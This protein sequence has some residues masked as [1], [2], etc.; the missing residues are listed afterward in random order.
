MTY[1]VELI[2]NTGQ[3][4]HVALTVEGAN[5]SQFF[6]K[7]NDFSDADKAKL[8]LFMAELE[9]HVRVAHQAA[10]AGDPLE[11]QEALV[12]GVLDAKVVGVQE[13]G[14]SALAAAVQAGEDITESWRAP[15]ERAPKPWENQDQAT[16]KVASG[17]LFD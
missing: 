16:P 2:V 12:K 10:L 9:S 7:L 15:V 8:G 14:K 13:P 6:D 17:S 11:P 4:Q 5:K 1:R 3:F